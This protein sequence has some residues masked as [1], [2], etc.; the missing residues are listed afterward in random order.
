MCTTFCEVLNNVSTVLEAVLMVLQILTCKA[1]VLTRLQRRVM[2]MTLGI[3][4]RS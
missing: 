3:V 4:P 2:Q 1:T